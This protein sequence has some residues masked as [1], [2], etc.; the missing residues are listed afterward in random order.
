MK[1]SHKLSKEKGS[2]SASVFK[3]IFSFISLW[4]KIDGFVYKKTSQTVKSGVQGRGLVKAWVLAGGRAGAGQARRPPRR[5]E[6]Y[7]WGTGGHWV[8]RKH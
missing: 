2:N 4:A 1:N 5:R 6:E 8:L 7:V 3:V